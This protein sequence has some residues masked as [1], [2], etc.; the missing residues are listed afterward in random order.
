MR[1]GLR[2]EKAEGA[3]ESLRV[4]GHFAGGGVE[5]EGGTHGPRA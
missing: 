5:G 4:D 2:E 3:S 1:K